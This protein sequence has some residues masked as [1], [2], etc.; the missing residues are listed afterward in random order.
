VVVAEHADHAD[1]A[2]WAAANAIPL[3]AAERAAWARVDS[4]RRLPPRFAERVRRGVGLA[5]RIINEPDLFHYNRVDGAY[6]GVGRTSRE[7]SGLVLN[8]K[9]GYAGAPETWQYHVGGQVRLS[10]SQR[11]WLGASYHDETTMRSTFGSRSSGPDPFNT[12]LFGIDR[13]D[14]YRERGFTGTVST[15]LLDFTRLDLQYDD[16]LQSSLPVLNGYSLFSG[17]QPIRSNPPIADGRLRTL[18]ATLT[19][20]SRPMMRR[21]RIDSRMRTN[22]STRVTL[23]AEAALPKLIPDD[24]DFRRYGVQ[25]EQR[26]R[27]LGL[28]ITTITA[29]AG[30]TTGQVPPQR[31]FGVDFGVRGLALQQGGVRSLSDS[32]S[33]GTRVATLTIRHDFGRLLFAHVPLVRRLPFT[34]SLDAGTFWTR[35]AGS[36]DSL[37]APTSL[38]SSRVG[39]QI[40]NLTPFLTPF[41]LG[42]RFNWRFG[43]IDQRR[44]FQFGIDLS[45]P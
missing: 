24:F 14:Y 4:V 12:L 43:A 30:L 7:I 33:Y 44:R 40:G 35:L 5:G 41:N 9:I 16:Q 21:L 31:E 10:E 25:I 19:Y 39:F 13:T 36:T 8:T 2:T 38:H 23:S 15:K 18:S 32:N 26:Q 1:S 3:S 6:L 37:G 45:G 28:G 27:T 20:D 22:T 34:L 29:A 17:R 42:L 11:F